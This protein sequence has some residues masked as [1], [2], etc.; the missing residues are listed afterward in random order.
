[1]HEACFPLEVV[2][3]PVELKKVRVRPMLKT[4]QERWD[5][6]MR[7][8][9]Y[10]G[11]DGPV[12]E[13]QAYV[14]T[15]GDQWVG[16][17]AFG[18]P[19][20]R[21]K[22]RENWIGWSVEQRRR[23]LNFVVQNRRFLILPGPKIPNLASRVLGLA[24][25][26]LNLDWEQK[27]GHPLLLVE[28][29]VDPQ[30]FEGTCYRAAG[31]E[32]LGRSAGF[33]R[34]RRD[35]YVEHEHPKEVWIKPLRRDAAG[36]LRG[37]DWPTAWQAHELRVL[38]YGPVR[39]EESRSLWE[40]FRK[41]SEFRK[42]RGMRYPL[43]AVLAC[44]ACATLAGAKNPAEMAEIADGFDQR[45]L[46]ALRCFRDRRTG[47]YAAPS[48]TTFRR[49]LG[50]IDSEQFDTVVAEWVRQR[51]TPSALAL[52]GKAVKGCLDAEG[53]P[54]FLVSA[55]GHGQAAPCGQVQVESKTNEIPAA[56]QLLKQIGPLDEVMITT[57]AAHA[58]HRTARAIVMEHGADYLLPLK[59]NQPSILKIAETL[60]PQSAFSPSSVPD[61]QR[62]WKIGT[63]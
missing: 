54:L 53:R 44:A 5:G 56:R 1:M 58:Q 15:I 57:D 51:E 17:L 41:V 45:H 21:L 60:L 4:E 46:R 50:G 9:H 31:W 33:G 12:G 47:R 29:F 20:Y 8:H 14:A 34:T 13:S 6:L 39:T 26:R 18:A 2:E 40:A 48:E 52:D 23:R 7:A 24:L 42:P 38:P 10:L 63:P 32:R 59:A 30:R 28:T 49:V 43:A 22:D 16:L 61:Q 19:A 37:T 27:Y 36:Q 35:F 62:T 11:W 25:R 55:V 3:E